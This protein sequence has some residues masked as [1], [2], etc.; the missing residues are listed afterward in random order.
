M[1]KHKLPI[2]GCVCFDQATQS[3]SCKDST[4]LDATYK[5]LC[6]RINVYMK[7]EHYGRKAIVILDSRD[8]GTNERNAKAITNFLVRSTYGGQM[9]SSILEI[10]MFAI[11]QAH[12]IGVQL[13]DLVTTIIGRYVAGEE[14]TY[15]LYERLKSCF[16]CWKDN[17]GRVNTTLRWI[18]PNRVS[19][20]KGTKNDAGL[21]KRQTLV[22]E[23]Q[24]SDVEPIK[25]V[26]RTRVK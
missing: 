18:D 14:N 15:Y 19:R 24:T 4:S 17:S 7:R 13:A 16:Y 8:D 2:F 21:T 22:R 1:G 6:E 12:N 3:F 9:R 10:P 20:V 23:G 25:T 5:S 26:I 11:S